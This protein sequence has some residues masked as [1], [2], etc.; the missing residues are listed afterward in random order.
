MEQTNKSFCVFIL[1]HGRPDKVYT[2][3][4]LEKDG[5]NGDCYVLV[6]NEDD[7]YPEYVKRYGEKVIQFDKAEI[8]KRTDTPDLSDERRTVIYARNA[9]FDIAK[10]MGYKYFLE[11]DDDY[12]SFC[13]RYIDGNSLKAKEIADVNVLFNAMVDFLIE[14]KALTVAIGQGVDYIGGADGGFWYKGLARKAMNTFFCSTDSPFQFVGRINE[15][16]N[17]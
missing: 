14:S 7:S 1:S 8:A 3:Q 4:T 16:V 12:T 5:F 15:D 11:L 17:T 6:D 13:V 10:R 2:Y 9:C